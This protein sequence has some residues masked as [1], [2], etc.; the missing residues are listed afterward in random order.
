MTCWPLQTPTSLMSANGSTCMWRRQAARLPPMEPCPARAGARTFN[1]SVWACVPS[2]LN[3]YRLRRREQSRRGPD[4][5]SPLPARAAAC[6]M[7]LRA[8]LGLL[9]AAHIIAAQPWAAPPPTSAPPPAGSA[10][11]GRRLRVCTGDR[12]PI[13]LCTGLDPSNYTGVRFGRRAHRARGPG[14]APDE[15][16]W[17]PRPH[18]PAC[19]ASRPTCRICSWRLSCSR[20]PWQGWA[21]R[22]TCWSGGAWA[23][24]AR[25]PAAA[26]AARPRPAQQACR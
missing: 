13:S 4:L 9:L 24:K 21:G 2:S 15:G 16:R 1:N 8:L 14:P 3:E 18:P 12:A 11:P 7:L 10:E 25:L 5:C 6:P 20:R 17:H 22:R 26:A 23:A 19:A